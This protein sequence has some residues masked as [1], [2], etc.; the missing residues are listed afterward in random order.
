MISRLMCLGSTII[1]LLYTSYNYW[2]RFLSSRLGQLIWVVTVSLPKRILVVSDLAGQ[3]T[4]R[5][6]I[7]ALIESLLLVCINRIVWSIEPWGQSCVWK[8][9]VRRKPRKQWNERSMH[10]SMILNLLTEFHH[11]YDCKYIMYL[12]LAKEIK[13]RDD[14]QVITVVKL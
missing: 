2:S 10:A 9:S 6:T 4:N 5:L 14:I 3:N 11:N 13:Y 1:L 8:M 12:C 7:N